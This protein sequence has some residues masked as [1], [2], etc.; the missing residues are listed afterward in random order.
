MLDKEQIEKILNEIRPALQSHGG[1]VELVEFNQKE[2]AVKVKL[3]GGC[4]SCPMAEITLKNVIEQT[5]KEKLP[6][7]K[8]VE[9]I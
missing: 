6:G 4:A 9:A 8:K 3:T 1:N 5:V 7:I 2:G